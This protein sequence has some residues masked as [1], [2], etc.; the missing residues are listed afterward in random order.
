[1][2]QLFLVAIPTGPVLELAKDLREKINN[3]FHLYSW[4]EPSLHATIEVLKIENNEDLKECEQIISSIV[5]KFKSFTLEVK[6]F[7]F[8]PPPH[9]AITLAIR[10]NYFIENLSYLI[11]EQLQAKGLTSREN[12]SGWKFHITIAGVFGADREWSEEEFYRASEM[13]NDISVQGRCVIERL[14]LWRPIISSEKKI[15]Q[16]FNLK[17]AADTEE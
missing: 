13:V 16:T 2:N 17:R 3:E 14:E 4:I 7:E 15:I 10:D 1:M 5:D 6:G 9:K 11:H 12:F 8:F